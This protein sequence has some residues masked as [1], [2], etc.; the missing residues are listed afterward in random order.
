MEEDERNDI[1]ETELKKSDRSFGSGHVM[2]RSDEG[3][4]RYEI[5][6]VLRECV[7]ER[8]NEFQGFF[9][10]SVDAY[11]VGLYID[12]LAGDGFHL[13]FGDHPDHALYGNI[14][15]GDH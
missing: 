2:Y 15:I 4:E 5:Y 12:V 7:S 9:S 11:G 10:V 6:F 13:A 3:S 14:G 8:L 1:N